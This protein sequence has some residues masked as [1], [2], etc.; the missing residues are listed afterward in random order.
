MQK[1]LRAAARAKTQAQR[2]LA[3]VQ[4]QNERVNQKVRRHEEGLIGQEIQSRIR[5][6]RDARKEDWLLGPLAPRRDV[7][8]LK[9]TYGTVSI[10][11]IRGIE[12]S[13]GQWK[14]WCIREGD[15]VVVVGKKQRDRGKIGTIKSVN[16][17]AEECMVNGLNVVSEASRFQITSLE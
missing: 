15:R 2:K 9:H 6:A 14:E 12:K 17:K 16:Q 4:A 3:R 11:Q 1:I 7:G 13:E 10:R 5:A 8:D